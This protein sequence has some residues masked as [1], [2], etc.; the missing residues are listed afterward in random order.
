M[1]L[2]GG[3]ALTQ[4]VNTMAHEGAHA[5]VGSAMGRRITG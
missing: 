2:P 5:V 1:M 3:W 4:H